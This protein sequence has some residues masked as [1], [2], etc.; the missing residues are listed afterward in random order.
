[1][2][3]AGARRTPWFDAMVAPAIAALVLVIGYPVLYTL[4]LSTLRLNLADMEPARAV[5]FRNYARLLADPVFWS[6]LVNTAIYTIGSVGIAAVAGLALALL[7]ESLLGWRFRLVRTF[8]LMPWAVPAVVVAF[9]FRFMFL[10][11]G[12]VINAILQR[13]GLIA[14]PVPWLNDA[15]L[16]LPSVMATNIW[17]MIPFFFL[18]LS[19]ALAA[20]PNEVIEAARVDRARVLGMVFHIKLP[21][22]RNALLISS[23]LMVISN[24]NDFAKVW[25]MTEGGPGYAT[26]TLV[27]YVYRLAFGD[28]NFGYASAIGVVWLVLLLIFAAFYLRAI[29]TP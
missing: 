25:A 13:A 23:L 18:L 22:L 12:G 14:A 7:T 6:A 20:I 1:M 19:A 4:Y 26:T 5:G 15:H 10:Q 2:Q 16:A 27:V 24:V 3:R 11:D 9:L 8:L 21:Y 28:F 17:T 29:R